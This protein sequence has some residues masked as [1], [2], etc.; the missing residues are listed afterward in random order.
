MEMAENENIYT[1]VKALMYF[2]KSYLKVPRVIIERMFASD[3]S[4]RMIGIVHW[5]L[6]CLCNYAD[7]YVSIKGK[8]VLCRRGECFITYEQLARFMEVDSRSVR[9]YVSSLESES[10]V[11][12]KRVS[13]RICFRVCGYERF[14]GSE[15]PMETQQ[16]GKRAGKSKKQIEPDVI[17]LRREE[18]ELKISHG[19]V[20]RTD[21]LK[22]CYEY[23]KE[24]N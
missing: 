16:E 6:F 11:E 5:L 1:D 19:N 23:G 22:S 20:P 9:R 10:L 12:V 14:T 18:A 13:G 24:C 15:V 17:G 8:Q 4:E 3:N 21:L 2:G 7:G